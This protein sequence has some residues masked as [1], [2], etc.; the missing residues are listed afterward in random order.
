MPETRLFDSLI[1]GRTARG[2]TMNWTTGQQSERGETESVQMNCKQLAAAD[3]RILVSPS[4]S[5]RNQ[6]NRTLLL[7]SWIWRLHV[8][9]ASEDNPA[10]TL[11]PNLSSLHYSFHQSKSTDR[12]YSACKRLPSLSL[13]RPM[14]DNC[15]I[16]SSFYSFES[17]VRIRMTVWHFSQL[18]VQPFF[19]HLF[20][21]IQQFTLTS[22]LV[23]LHRT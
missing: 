17:W 21:A 6:G 15:M 22:K 20:A 12:D 8:G 13:V 2:L 16:D 3:K 9:K 1:S 11:Q 14:R 7:T 18:S 10:N 23:L 5:E 4:V 19:V